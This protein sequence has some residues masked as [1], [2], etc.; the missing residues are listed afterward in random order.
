M[1]RRWTEQDITTMLDLREKG[2]T[3]SEIGKKLSRSAGAVQRMH[4]AMTEAR[5]IPG[6][7]GGQR[8]SPI[9]GKNLR[10]QLKSK[11]ITIKEFAEMCGASPSAARY[12]L[13]ANVM[14]RM[15]VA[16]I[17]NVYGIKYEDI[18]PVITEIP[19]RPPKQEEKGEPTHHAQDVAL[20]SEER[21]ALYDLIFKAVYEGVKKALNE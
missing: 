16:G 10:E 21:A 6:L 4:Y 3:F 12:W 1:G 2:W 14:P 19:E 20:S 13:N 17:R 7:C 11:G 8:L 15:A 5:E 18:K 9:N